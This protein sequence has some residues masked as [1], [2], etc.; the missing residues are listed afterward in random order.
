MNDK[1]GGNRGLWRAVALAVAAAV[2]GQL[3]A[4]S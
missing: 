3:E 1:T 4:G 2:T